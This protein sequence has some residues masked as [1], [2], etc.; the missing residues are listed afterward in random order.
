MKVL[1]VPLCCCFL[2]N[3]NLSRISYCEELSDGFK[4]IFF[5]RGEVFRSN[6]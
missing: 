2:D 1:I 4:K 3:P 5:V 6:S